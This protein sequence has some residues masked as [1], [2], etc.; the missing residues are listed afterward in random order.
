MQASHPY[1][2]TDGDGRGGPR[3]GPGVVFSATSLS[4]GRVPNQSC[5][6]WLQFM[7]VAFSPAFLVLPCP[8]VFFLLHNGQVSLLLKQNSTPQL[9]FLSCP[10]SWWSSLFIFLHLSFLCLWLLLI[11]S[12]PCLLKPAQVPLFYCNGPGW[13]L[14]QVCLTRFAGPFSVF[15]LSP[16]PSHGAVWKSG[17]WPPQG[18][19]LPARPPRPEP[20]LSSP[21]P[22]GSTGRYISHLMTC[23]FF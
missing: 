12:L 2:G 7:S 1:R 19:P 4:W 9:L 10:S 11:H 14:S 8:P 23:V 5:F 21:F 22:V 15:I 20:L 6:Y 13:G 16:S 18:P 17:W 3:I